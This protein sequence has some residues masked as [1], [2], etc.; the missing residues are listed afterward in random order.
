MHND[1]IET[2]LLRHYGSIA[3]TPIDLEARVCASVRQEAAA[4]RQQ[5]RTVAHWQ[6]TRVSRRHAVKLVAI[7]ATGLSLLSLGL[8][9]L[10]AFEAS[11]VGQDI[12][13]HAI[14]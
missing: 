3:Q 7:G 14:P 5:Q 6:Q 11:L 12:T 8:E 13:Q 2:L 1:S 4:L 10:Q 9:S